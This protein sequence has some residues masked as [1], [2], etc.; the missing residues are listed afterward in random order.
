MLTIS[1]NNCM[2]KCNWHVS[3][4]C[5]CPVANFKSNHVPLLKFLFWQTCLK[6]EKLLF[7]SKKKKMAEN[8]KQY[9]KMS[10]IKIIS[11][12]LKNIYLSRGRTAKS[13]NVFG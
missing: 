11:E 12:F 1:A 9:L 2:R 4:Q 10:Y 8:V 7:S 3:L 6:D 13:E 5:F